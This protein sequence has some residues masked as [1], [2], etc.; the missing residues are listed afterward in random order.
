MQGNQAGPPGTAAP[1]WYPDPASPGEQRYWDGA[2]WTGHTAPLAG[3]AGATRRAKSPVKL[4]VGLGVGLA[5]VLVVLGV[6]AVVGI[7]RIGGRAVDWISEPMDT[8]NEYLAAVEAGDFAEADEM[9]CD[10]SEDFE[11]DLTEEGG[12]DLVRYNAYRM[13][14]VNN[15]GWVLFDYETETDSGTAVAHLEPRDGTLKICDIT[16]DAPPDVFDDDTQG[17]F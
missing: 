12:D 16:S 8:V 1:G 7:V 4:L 11:I 13:E 3:P 2:A 14:R 15:R 10:G 9:T 6:L 5:V 17:G